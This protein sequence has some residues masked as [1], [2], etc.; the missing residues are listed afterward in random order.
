MTTTRA[1]RTNAVSE[2][3]IAQRQA[4]ILQHTAKVIVAS[5][6]AGCT[7]AAVAEE[8]GFSIGMLQHHF[9]TR[10]RLINACLYRQYVDAHDRY[11]A[12]ATSSASSTE[13]LCALLDYTSEGETEIGD[14]WGFWIEVTAA[15]RLDASLREGVNEQ[16]TPWLQQFEM[17]FA[18]VIAEAAPDALCTAAELANMLVGMADG[19]AIHAMNGTYDMDP[20]RMRRLLYRFTEGMLQIQLDGGAR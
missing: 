12:L 9:R 16:A 14:V 1:R 19:L 7:L 3:E 4:E 2:A 5:G 13:R 15:A 18:Q 17:T 6:V 11:F 8:S 10:D 20:P